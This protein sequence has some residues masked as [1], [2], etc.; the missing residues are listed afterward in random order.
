MK[1]VI[2]GPSPCI[3]GLGLGHSI[4]GYDVVCR[5]NSSY[6]NTILNPTD[7]GTKIDVEFA[8]FNSEINNT[9]LD[10]LEYLQSNFPIRFISTK[11]FCYQNHSD[12]KTLKTFPFKVEQTKYNCNRKFYNTGSIAIHEILQ[13]WEDVDELFICGY[14]FHNEKESSYIENYPCGKKRFLHNEQKEKDFF[15]DNILNHPKANIH[16]STFN[17]LHSK[18]ESLIPIH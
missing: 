2:V 16:E 14:S 12:M 1:V 18:R 10:N 3:V 5:V 9:I 7:Y 6:M 4:D 17:A 13:N 15:K 11:H 8:T